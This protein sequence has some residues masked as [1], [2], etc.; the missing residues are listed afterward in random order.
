MKLKTNIK[1]Q[2]K[3][4]SNRNTMLILVH[5]QLHLFQVLGL[6]EDVLQTKQWW[7]K[8]DLASSTTSSLPGSGSVWRCSAHKTLVIQGWSCFIYNSTSSRFWVCVKMLCTQDTG[9]TRL[10]LLHL[11]LNLL[12]VL[13]LSDLASS[14]FWVCVKRPN[15]LQNSLQ[16]TF[17]KNLFPFC[18]SM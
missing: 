10:I 6:C 7:Y 5:L 8:A 17:S 12:Q 11:H 3:K 2:K 18:I 9:D 4:K 1:E 14:G 13:G 15:G 16:T